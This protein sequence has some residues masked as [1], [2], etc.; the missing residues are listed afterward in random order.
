[1]DIPSTMTKQVSEAEKLEISYRVLHPQ[2]IIQDKDS[3]RNIQIPYS[4]STFL[5]FATF[6]FLLVFP[7][8]PP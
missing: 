8:P 6:F 7:F 4:S 2:A 1:M 3:S 5:F